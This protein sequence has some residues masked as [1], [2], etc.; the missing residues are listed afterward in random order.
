[1]LVIEMKVH[2]LLLPDQILLSYL[3]KFECQRL[4]ISKHSFYSYVIKI[5]ADIK[6]RSL[7]LEG[8][9]R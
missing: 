3:R 1:M 5:F 2:V 7:N 8:L 4:L 9:F 6:K